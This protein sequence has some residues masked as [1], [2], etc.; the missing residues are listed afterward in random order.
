MRLDAQTFDHAATDF[1]LEG[2]HRGVDCGACHVR[3]K[4]PRAAPGACIDCHRERDAH[5]GALGKDCATCHGVEDW[6]K[7]RFD[8][9]KATA[10]RWPLTGAHTTVD[11][12]LCH[13][14]ER[15]RQTPTACVDCH[16]IDDVH[17]GARGADCADCHGTDAWKKQKFDHHRETG[18]ALTQGHG[19]LA[20]QAC[21][22]GADM[23]EVNGK[24]C[25]DC[26]AADDVHRGQQG[27]LCGDCHTTQRWNATNF[28]HARKTDFP[29]RGA[30][31]TLACGVCHK[32]E[33]Q[34]EKL[35][36]DCIG[37]HR[38]DDVHAGGLGERCADCHGEQRWSRDIRFDH[39]LTGFGLIGLHAATTC[40]ACH[41]DRRFNATPSRCID[42]H[43]ADDAHQGHLGEQCA[44]CH[45]PNDWRLWTFDHDTQTDFRIDGAHAAAACVACHRRPPGEGRELPR[46][47]G[48]CHRQDDVHGGEFGADC[49]RCHDTRSFSGARRTKP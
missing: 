28:D 1:R 27:Q 20:C 8:H 39:D 3:D 43:R 30:H 21:H 44:D 12:G 31:A 38:G 16:R 14:G 19:G 17:A 36:G 42:C 40:E 33:T 22:R 11:C 2:A 37:C 10:S 46:D 6:R 26:H 29:L 23:R 15:Y 45:T 5:R 48:G 41:A 32:G 35:R 49:A 4:P 47:C 34:A 24:S 7:V 25:V 18:F 9:G 13:A